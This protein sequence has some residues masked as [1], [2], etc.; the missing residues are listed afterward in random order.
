[1]S[2]GSLSLFGRPVA[3][4][5]LLLAAVG[6]RPG[7]V[8]AAQPT[9]VG[10]ELREKA[11][12]LGLH[13]HQLP[14]LPR[15][16]AAWEKTLLPGSTKVTWSSA[17]DLTIQPGVAAV[18][19]PDPKTRRS[20]ARASS[21]CVV[22]RYGSK[23]GGGGKSVDP[24]KE[25]IR[26]PSMLYYECG[27]RAYADVSRAAAGF[28]R[29]AGKMRSDPELRP[30]GPGLI[31]PPAGIDRVMYGASYQRKGDTAGGGRLWLVLAGDVVG[32]LRVAGVDFQA[33]NPRSH[34][35]ALSQSEATATYNRWVATL[36]T[37]S[38]LTIELDTAHKPPKTR[39]PRKTDKWTFAQGDDF[40]LAG[41]VSYLGKPVEGATVGLVLVSPADKRYDLRPP[42]KGSRSM[43]G[44]FSEAGTDQ[45][46]DL[47]PSFTTD[48]A[49][50]FRWSAF[51]S[52]HATLGGWRL[53]AEATWTD[54]ATASEHEARCIQEIPVVEDGALTAGALEANF[55]WIQAQWKRRMPR[56]G[57]IQKL[58]GFDK[59]IAGNVNLC[60]NVLAFYMPGG[61]RLKTWGPVNNFY[62]T[63]HGY[64]YDR[65]TCGGIA[66]RTLNFL[67]DIRYSDDQ[68]TRKRMLGIGYMP[69]SHW[70]AESVFEEAKA[71]RLKVEVE[72]VDGFSYREWA[73]NHIA[74]MLYYTAGYAHLRRA[75]GIEPVD[76]AYYRDPFAPGVAHKRISYT[77][78]PQAVVF[79]YWLNQQRD[80]LPAAD[81]AKEFAFGHLG[82]PP[83]AWRQLCQVPGWKKLPTKPDGPGTYAVSKLFVGGEPYLM[84]AVRLRARRMEILSL[85]PVWLLATDARG[86]ATGVRADGRIVRSIPGSS[87]EY[88][89]DG[90]GTASLRLCVP[91]G[92]VD[93]TVT[94]YRE[95]TFGLAVLSADG[96]RELSFAKKLPIKPG[97]TA[98]LRLAKGLPAARLAM[99]DGT[100]VAAKVAAVALPELA[101]DPTAYGLPTER[102]TRCEPPTAMPDIASTKARTSSDP[103]SGRRADPLPKGFN[104]KLLRTGPGTVFAKNPFVGIW[105]RDDGRLF[106]ATARGRLYA[107]GKLAGTYVWDGRWIYRLRWSDGPVEVIVVAKAGHIFAGK[108]TA[109]KATT[110]RRVKERRAGE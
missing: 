94:G 42:K 73:D 31:K 92:E 64:P 80:I 14:K 6:V 36:A 57:P 98:R 16:F 20:V 19:V 76:V 71:D 110:G 86:R 2:N 25:E 104:R 54:P 87:V 90:D 91:P 84:G 65:F 93:L 47:M 66:V 78:Q 15:G 34:I 33:S 99:P 96:K 5:L 77:I 28:D 88:W 72:D 41:T 3:L 83:R 51:F 49:G 22:R 81:W 101:V 21:A 102:P 95:G 32:L 67:N 69:V 43:R 82:L 58:G 17:P 7:A 18:R 59:V 44:G 62:A 11:S 13:A 40:P 37:G 12:R 108:T 45:Q 30:M 8:G 63:W 4:A 50:R 1:M 105:R 29:L 27:V 109:G 38:R 24:M 39:P 100:E 97:Q 35:P 61:Y 56:S 26:L 9:G 106:A 10:A 68:A 70:P 55:R 46:A 60:R 85:S 89:P 75:L 107:A 23:I 79:E 74:V 52:P 48:A 103:A 53:E